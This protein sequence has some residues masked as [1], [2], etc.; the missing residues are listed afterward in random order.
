MLII[1]C[2]NALTGD[3]I[4][5]LPR[6]LKAFWSECGMHTMAFWYN[7]FHAH[8]DVLQIMGSG[9]CKSVTSCLSKVQI[10]EATKVSIVLQLQVCVWQ[11]PLKDCYTNYI[12]NGMS[13][14]IAAKPQSVHNVCSKTTIICNETFTPT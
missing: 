2:D 10:R 9:L 13:R 12:I 7:P 3:L 4:P 5:L 11:Q 6:A 8:G 14:L 1:D